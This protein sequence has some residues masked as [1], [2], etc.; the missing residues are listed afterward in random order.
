MVNYQR[1]MRKVAIIIYG[2]P[3]SGKGTQA[4]LISWKRDYFHFD[5]GRYL[6]SVIRDPANRNNKMIQREKRL[7]DAGILM[8][9]SWV[10]GMTTKQAVTVGKSGVSIIFSGSPRTMYEAFGDEKRQGLVKTIEEYYGKKN[11][12]FFFL[13]VRPETSIK[14][15][16]VRRVCS[17]CATVFN[18]T[19]RS[20]H[21]PICYGILRKRSLDN[22]KV[23]RDRLIE[24]DKRTMPIL[25]ELEKRK[26]QVFKINAEPLPEFVFKQ[27]EKHLP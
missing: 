3:G 2:P 16:S 12:Y 19:T 10:L 23:I 4:N 21:C 15:N 9:P 18:P 17:V 11:T 24:Y 7:F 27:I 26:Y 20:K 5:S 25:A 1:Q 13:K 6:E 14:R 8:T 22:P